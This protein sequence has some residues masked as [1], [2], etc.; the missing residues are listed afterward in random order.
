MNGIFCIFKYKIKSRTKG[1]YTCTYE[2]LPR[3]YTE[4]LVWKFLT[5]FAGAITRVRAEAMG[6]CAYMRCKEEA[7]II[8]D[9][10]LLDMETAMNLFV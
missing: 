1:L 2:S 9:S 10:R 6:L 3:L 5:Y 4:P 7:G 8:F